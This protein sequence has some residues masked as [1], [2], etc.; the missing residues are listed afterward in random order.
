MGGAQIVSA[1]HH[2]PRKLGTIAP[3]SCSEADFCKNQRSEP[4]LVTHYTPFFF[5]GGGMLSV[6]ASPVFSGR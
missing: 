3:S 4:A 1:D 2:I 5:G 6:D